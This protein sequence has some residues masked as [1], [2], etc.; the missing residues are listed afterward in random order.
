[1]LKAF[2]SMIGCNMRITVKVRGES[3]QHEVFIGR[4]D[5]IFT[6]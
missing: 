3:F 2:Q 1:M 5:D 4:T 6:I